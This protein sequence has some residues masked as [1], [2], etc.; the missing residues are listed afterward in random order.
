MESLGREG[1]GADGNQPPVSAQLVLC[2]QP[3]LGGLGSALGEGRDSKHSKVWACLCWQ[4]SQVWKS[5]KGMT[6]GYF[7]NSLHLPLFLPW[8]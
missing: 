6:T 3:W 5:Q 8:G 7:W 4:N 2:G 1:W